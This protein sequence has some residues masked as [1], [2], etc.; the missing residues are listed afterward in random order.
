MKKS[1]LIILTSI[2][3]IEVLLLLLLTLALPLGV[4]P[5]FSDL[6]R[7]FGAKPHQSYFILQRFAHLLWLLPILDIGL[8][9][10]SVL[11]KKKTWFFLLMGFVLLQAVM[12]LIPLYSGVFII[13][14]ITN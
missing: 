11:A 9:L 12:I 13:P 10:L 6:Y 14:T 2:C 1:T 4:L 3:V 5:Y 8:L 7:S